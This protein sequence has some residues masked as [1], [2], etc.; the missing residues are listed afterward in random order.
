M[1]NRQ[2]PHHIVNPDHPDLARATDDILA[3]ELDYTMRQYLRIMSKMDA[4]LKNTAL[5]PTEMPETP[6]WMIKGDMDFCLERYDA[7][8]EEIRYRKENMI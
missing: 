8:I 6:L 4:Y 5:E 1:T 7:I 2:Q 3:L